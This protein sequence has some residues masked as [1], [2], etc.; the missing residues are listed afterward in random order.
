MQ[1]QN[2]WLTMPKPESGADLD[3]RNKQRR[4]AS[5]KHDHSLQPDELEP[6]VPASYNDAPQPIQQQEPDHNVLLEQPQDE[7]YMDEPPE[8]LPQ[9]NEQ[10]PQK[11][12]VGSK[13]ATQCPT[14]PAMSASRC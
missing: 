14:C 10:H 2:L 11:Q 3:S 13:T 8:L 5:A 4:L 7:Q 6:D 12:Q 1:F 9:E